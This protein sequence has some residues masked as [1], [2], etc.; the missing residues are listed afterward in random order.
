MEGRIQ[1][2]ASD[3]VLRNK[4][5]PLQIIM[6][7]MMPKIMAFNLEKQLWNTTKNTKDYLLQ[8]IS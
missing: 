8:T 4:W 6:V 1:Y 2:S 7:L 5:T 3:L